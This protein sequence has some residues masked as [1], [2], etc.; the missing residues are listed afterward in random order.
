MVL[1]NNETSE[2]TLAAAPS[3]GTI[4]AVKR[5]PPK[6]GE[7]NRETKDIRKCSLCRLHINPRWNCPARKDVRYKFQ[8]KGQW[9]AVCRGQLSA[10]T[11]SE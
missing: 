7:N 9:A 10:T 1:Q 3:D 6:S 5:S 4:A 8:K 2:A 11:T